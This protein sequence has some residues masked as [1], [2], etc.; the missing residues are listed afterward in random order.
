MKVNGMYIPATWRSAAG[1]VRWNRSLTSSWLTAVARPASSASRTA[2][3]NA[4]SCALGGPLYTWL[5]SSTPG[6]SAGAASGPFA[7]ELAA[8]PASVVASM[9]T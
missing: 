9:S 4:L 5:E 8:Q 6:R 1:H 7:C 3:Q 2:T